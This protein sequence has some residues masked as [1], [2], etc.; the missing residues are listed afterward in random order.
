MK[1]KVQPEISERNR[2]VRLFKEQEDNLSILEE[3]G[4]S[5]QK[6]VREAMERVIREKMQL[7]GIEAKHS[8]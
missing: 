6:L 7:I 5:V 8:N 2:T 1:T 3:H 4:F